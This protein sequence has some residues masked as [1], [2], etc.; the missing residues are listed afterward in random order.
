MI[1]G[2]FDDWS[3]ISSAVIDSADDVHDTDG[4]P[5]GG[6]PSYVEYSDVDIIE[7]K[8]TNDAENLYGYIKATGKIGR[9]SSD[10]LGHEKK[11]RYYFIFTI[12]VDDNDTTGYQLKDGGYYPD[13]RGYDMNMEV[14]F[15]NGGFN[16]GHYINHEFTSEEEAQTQGLIDLENGIVNLAPGSYD[17]Y[18]QW[19]TFEDSSYVVVEDRGPV[20][21]GIITIAVSE[22][23]HEAEIKAPMW[24]FLNTPDGDRIIDVGQYIDIS[25]SLEGS[26]EL[27]ES[28]ANAGYTPG[29][30][31]VWGSDTAE[32]FHYFV[33]GNPMSISENLS[34]PTQLTLNP[35]YPNPFNSATTISY[36]LPHIETISLKIY[37]I[38]G[39]EVITLV[40]AKQTAGTHHTSW[41]SQDKFGQILS[42][43]IYITVLEGKKLKKIQ[44]MIFIK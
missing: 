37:D 28:A 7:V 13:S 6:S 32:P 27:S 44:P 26:G 8:F 22:D 31:S 41:D 3:A 12:D 38:T 35:N 16:T 21:Q 25:A 4:Y 2:Q 1:D 14:E 10:T 43:G 33:T 18:T 24:G 20:Y 39:R 5:E 36:Y 40:N 17:Y 15:Y 19:V 23:G 9:T 30:H 42:S 11:G 34:Q 29:S